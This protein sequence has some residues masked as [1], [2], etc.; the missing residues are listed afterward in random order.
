MSVLMMD[1]GGTEE[2]EA[3]MMTDLVGSRVDPSLPHPNLR[4]EA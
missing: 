1:R 4:L 3:L 2:P